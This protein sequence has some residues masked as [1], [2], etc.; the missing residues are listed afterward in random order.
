LREGGWNLFRLDE[1]TDPLVTYKRR[2]CV[3][4]GH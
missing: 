1:V 4:E 3:F 2:I